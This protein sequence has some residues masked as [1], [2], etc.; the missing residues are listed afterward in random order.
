[1]AADK[2][3][4]ADIREKTRE[5]VESTQREKREEVTNKQRDFDAKDVRDY[6]DINVNKA[7]QSRKFR[8]MGKKYTVQ[9]KDMS[10]DISPT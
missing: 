7:Y 1:M 10:K 8:T 5:D 3:T 2:K 6:Y 9:F 4:V